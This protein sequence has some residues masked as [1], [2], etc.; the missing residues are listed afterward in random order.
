MPVVGEKGRGGG[1]KWWSKNKAV[2][3]MPSTTTSS[4]P[5]RVF[6][7]WREKGSGFLFTEGAL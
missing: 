5:R 7:P 6:S 4:R 1:D 2:V 3:E